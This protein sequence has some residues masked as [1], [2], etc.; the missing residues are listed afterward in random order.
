[1]TSSYSFLHARV[2][3]KLAFLKLSTLESVFEKMLFHRILVNG[4]LNRR[5]TYPFQTKTD[6]CGPGLHV[7]DMNKAKNF[8]SYLYLVIESRV[9]FAINANLRIDSSWSSSFRTEFHIYRMFGWSLN[10]KKNL[11]SRLPGRLLNEIS[12]KLLL[13]KS[14]HEV[15]RKEI[16]KLNES[17]IT[18]CVSIK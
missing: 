3:E 14:K 11:R 7:I 5:K 10:S 16:N 13:I 15:V 17:I 4:R 9:Q 2:N 12:T 18:I 8:N 6:T 1:M